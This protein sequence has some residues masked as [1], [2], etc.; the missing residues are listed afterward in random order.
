MPT[1]KKIAT[2]E[3]LADRLRRS[4][5]IV[6]TDYRGLRMAELTAVRR[7]LQDAGADYR[8]VK[9]TLARRAAVLAER[10]DVAQVLTGPTALAMGFGDAIEPVKLLMEHIRTHRL[11]LKI[12]GGALDGR[13]LSDR[14]IT[15]LALLPGR[16]ELYGQVVGVLQA[17]LSGLVGVLQG[18]L[19]SLVGVLQARRAQLTGGEA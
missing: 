7:R 9:N 5:I 18:N 3:V 13:A 19:R 8:V 15:Q 16:T 2:V 12:T 11:A 4:T 10:D 17:P 1:K 6:A 14:D